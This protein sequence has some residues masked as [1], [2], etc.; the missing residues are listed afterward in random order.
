MARLYVAMKAQAWVLTLGKNL[1][2]RLKGC[3]TLESAPDEGS[4]FTI[5][6]PVSL[7]Y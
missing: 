5:I 1:A 7:A 6:I 4:T 2:Q 3:I